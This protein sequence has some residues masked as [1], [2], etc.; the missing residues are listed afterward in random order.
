M[1][2]GPQRAYSLFFV[3][4]ARTA[5]TRVHAWL[6][7]TRL[8]RSRRSTLTVPAWS[9]GPRRCRR[10][11]GGLVEGR[12]R[13]RLLEPVGWWRTGGGR[14]P[15]TLSAGPD[16][17]DNR[18]PGFTLAPTPRR[19]HPG[20]LDAAVARRA[21]ALQALP[22]VLPP[23]GGKLRPAGVRSRH[24]QQQRVRQGGGDAGGHHPRV[25]LPHADAVRLGLRP[26]HGSGRPLP[27]AA[28]YAAARN[29]TTSGVGPE[30]SGSP[31]LVRGQLGDHRGADSAAVRPT[32]HDHPP[33][34]GD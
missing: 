18:R 16:L 28:D 1:A 27:S 13:P 31:R 4:T 2:P 15:S 24:Q 9:G 3:P 22:A 10:S 25:L 33:S 14:A 8:R 7:G 5:L 21:S 20:F 26:L 34:G 23:G 32:Q 30:D 12:D 17:H 29:Q 11:R 19:G 6:A